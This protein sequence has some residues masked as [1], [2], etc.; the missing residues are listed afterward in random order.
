MAKKGFHT[1]CCYCRRRFSETVELLAKTID[2]FWPSS[3][4]GKNVIENKLECCLECNR[5][6]ADKMPEDW[7]KIV[8]NL[9]KRK[10]WYWTYCRVDYA[11]II[12]S[13]RHFIKIKKDSKISDYKA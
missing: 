9:L 10:T 2:H 6:K 5:W 8:E 1:H 7:L 11:Q 3:R 13:V 4:T 12:G